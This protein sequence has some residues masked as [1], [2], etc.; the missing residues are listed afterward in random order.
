MKIE[1][2]AVGGF[3]ESGRNMTAVKV[4][5]EVVILDMGLHMPKYI[6]ITEE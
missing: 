6:S 5:D 2:C 3:S 4:D 1:I